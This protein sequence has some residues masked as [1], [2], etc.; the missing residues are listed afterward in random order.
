MEWD[1]IE[2]PVPIPERM[3]RH[4]QQACDELEV[5]WMSLP[6]RAS[7]DAA[8]IASVTPIGMVFVPSRDGKSHTPEEWTEFE[9]ITRGVAVLG[10]A[11]MR[12]DE[13]EEG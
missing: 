12:L 10:R 3:Q 6:S 13:M 5:R 4:I 1:T 8:R 11:L 7:H 2:E 9:D